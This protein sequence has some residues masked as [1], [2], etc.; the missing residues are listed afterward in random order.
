[1]AKHLTY[2]AAAFFAALAVTTST[3]CAAES[4][5][6]SEPAALATATENAT[7]Q[8]VW[9]AAWQAQRPQVVTRKQEMKKTYF[10]STWRG[11]D[12]GKELARALAEYADSGLLPPQQYMTTAQRETFLQN[13]DVFQAAF[14]DGNVADVLMMRMTTAEFQRALGKRSAQA[15]R[16]GL[17]PAPSA[18]AKQVLATLM[19]SRADVQKQ[20]DRAVRR[21]DERLTEDIFV[22]RLMQVRAEGKILQM[23]ADFAPIMDVKIT[24]YTPLTRRLANGQPYWEQSARYRERVITKPGEPPMEAVVTCIVQLFPREDGWDIAYTLIDGDSKEK[25]TQTS[26]RIGVLLIF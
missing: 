10:Q 22:A 23:R 2:L 6:A 1:M 20:L 24:A 7:A 11:P 3:S 14:V 4:V 18:S 17:G 16:D 5:V 12:A 15:L 21:L 19:P 13:A 8:T 25:S 26:K 9:Q